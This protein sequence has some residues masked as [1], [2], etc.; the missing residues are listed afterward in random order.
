MN[1]E[2]IE[3]LT[4]ERQN[5]ILQ[6]KHEKINNNDKDI[7]KSLKNKY[8]SISNK[9]NYLQNHDRIKEHKKILNKSY[10]TEETKIK[11]REYMKQYYKNVMNV[12]KSLKD[13]KK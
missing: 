6:I 7:L 12:Y 5:I 1:T 9:I 10:Q 8:H 3:V 11:H 13:I 2:K 4:N